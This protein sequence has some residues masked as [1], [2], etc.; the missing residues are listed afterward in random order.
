MTTDSL[1][2]IED[3]GAEAWARICAAADDITHPMRLVTL[4]TV[5]RHGAADGRLMILRGADR[6]SARLWLHA[7][8]GSSKLDQIRATPGVCL[9]AWDPRDGVQLRI[10]GHATTHTQDAMQRD[11]VEQLT[12]RLERM[13][14]DPVDRREVGAQRDPRSESFLKSG[15]TSARELAPRTAVIEIRVRAIGWTQTRRR[16]MRNALLTVEQGWKATGGSSA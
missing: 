2:P 9:V 7:D 13:A 12:R 3:A 5:D 16:G 8:P 4:C 11:H 6:E 14:E 15:A 10:F 1:L